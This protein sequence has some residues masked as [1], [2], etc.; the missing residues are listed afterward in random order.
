MRGMGS[1]IAAA[2]GIEFGNAV[3]TARGVLHAWCGR[4][5][6]WLFVGAIHAGIVTID[7]GGRHAEAILHRQRDATGGVVLELG[8]ADE[9][10]G[11]VIGAVQIVSREI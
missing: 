5:R 4:D 11:I 10:V 9:D 2:G 3:L 6:N 7:G 8:H 1:R